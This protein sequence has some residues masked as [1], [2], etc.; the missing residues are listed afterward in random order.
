M[1][2]EPGRPLLIVDRIEAALEHPVVDDARERRHARVHGG[3]EEAQPRLV[4]AA[5][6]HHQPEPVAEALQE[7]H[8]QA[9]LRRLD[10]QPVI[11]RARARPREPLGHAQHALRAVDR[12]LEQV[13]SQLPGEV[14]EPLRHERQVHLVELDEALLAQ[15]APAGAACLGADE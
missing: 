13:R 2:G 11:G 12:Q 7:P 8:Q 9:G 10:G 3:E 5:P 4:V 14:L 1:A 6:S 15:P